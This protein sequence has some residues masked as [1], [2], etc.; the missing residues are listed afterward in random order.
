MATDVEPIDIILSNFKPVLGDAYQPYRSHAVRVCEIAKL[1]NPEVFVEEK[2]AVAAAFHDLGIW[3]NQTWDYLKPSEQMACDFLEKEN[4][5]EWKNEITAMIHHHHKLSSYK[6][7]DLP[8]VELFR[9]A[10]LVDF[11][12]GLIRFGLKREQYKDLVR[13]FPMEGFHRELARHFWGHLKRNPLSPFP[14]V[15]W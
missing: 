13:D 5:S 9:K 4:K 11:S 10:D 1:L 8:T 12:A 15:R 7:E 3:V 14:M 2:F 6:G